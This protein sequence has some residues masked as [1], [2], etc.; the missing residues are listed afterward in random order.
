MPDMQTFISDLDIKRA[1]QVLDRQRLGK[2]RLEARQIYQ[3]IAEGRK[4][5]SHHPAVLMYRDYL[6]FLAFYGQTICDEWIGRGYKDSQRPFFAAQVQDS[7]PPPWLNEA[8]VTAHRSN[9]VR[10]LP[11]HY[12]PLWPGVNPDLPYVWPVRADRS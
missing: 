2:S 12:G 6:P 10:K 11:A 4:A 9:L 3:T 8:F 7:T 1:A 5:W